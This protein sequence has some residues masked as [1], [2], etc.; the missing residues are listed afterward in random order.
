M[1]Q[2]IGISLIILSD[3]LFS[4]NSDKV[5]IAEDNTLAEKSAEIILSKVSLEAVFVA[6]EYEVEFYANAEGP[7]SKW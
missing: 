2:N 5:D 1:K 3:V 4:C 6:L 7:L